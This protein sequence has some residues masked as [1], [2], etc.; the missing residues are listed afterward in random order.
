V[1]NIND[2]SMELAKFP[3]QAVETNLVEAGVAF[4][5][6]PPVLVRD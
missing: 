4:T 5:N 1:L 6:V 3:F 2:R